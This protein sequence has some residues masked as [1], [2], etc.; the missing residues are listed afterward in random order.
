[1][2]IDSHCDD[3]A[4]LARRWKSVDVS[5]PPLGVPVIAYSHVMRDSIIGWI[6]LGDNN[7]YGF[8]DDEPIPGVTHWMY[9]PCDPMTCNRAALG[10]SAGEESHE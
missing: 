7:W 8:G 1:M 6:S 10:Q 5:L 9:K 2:P 3:C 4:Y